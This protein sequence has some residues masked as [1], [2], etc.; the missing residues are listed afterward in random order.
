MK[1]LRLYLSLPPKPGGMEKHIYFLT[2]H[3]KKNHDVTVFFNSGTKLSTHDKKF[4][5]FL[6]LHKLRPNFLGI[7]LFYIIV[8]LYLAIKRKKFDVIHIHGDWSSLLFG[9]TIKKQTSSQLLL[10]SIHGDITSG[11]FHKKVLPRLLNSVDQVFVTGH[12]AAQTINQF[13]AKRAVFQPSGI[14]KIYTSGKSVEKQKT[15]FKVITV[16]N[17]VKVKNITFLLSIAKKMNNISFIIVGDGP[18]KK[19][20]INQI[21][22]NGISNVDL[23]G[24]KDPKELVGLYKTSN[25][26]LMTS[27]SEGTPTSIMEAMAC[28]LPIISSNAGGIQNLVLDHING[29][30]IPDF[31]V[32]H[33]MEKIN[34]LEK[35][36]QLRRQIS[37]NNLE[38]SRSFTWEV[39]EEVITSRT[40]QLYKEI[41]S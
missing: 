10:F 4:L 3:Q 26:F 41:K 13:G 14:D 23:L 33:Y 6:N 18:E 2:E 20:L 16:A 19:Q 29:F 34:I 22:K 15:D 32:S 8:I 35:N 28:G 30:V 31:K 7:F 21:L 25:C 39:V 27:L 40:A 38:A 5:P 17:L 24:Y 1:I 9:R 37:Q 36:L 11:F 12:K